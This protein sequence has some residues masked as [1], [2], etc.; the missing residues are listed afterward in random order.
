MLLNT[1]RPSNMVG[2]TDQDDFT[3]L[4][5]QTEPKIVQ[6][7]FQR[8]N[9]S[10]E[11]WDLRGSLTR[12]PGDGDYPTALIGRARS[13]CQKARSMEYEHGPRILTPTVQALRV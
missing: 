13:L 3:L 7:V 5:P 6:I 9:K 11:V 12:F 1:A 4:L 2:H 10:T 8:V